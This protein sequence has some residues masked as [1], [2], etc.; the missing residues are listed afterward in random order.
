MFHSSLFV[1]IK[2]CIGF[3]NLKMWYR[4]IK[5]LLYNMIDMIVILT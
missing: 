1:T 2:F 3:L 4:F 5:L